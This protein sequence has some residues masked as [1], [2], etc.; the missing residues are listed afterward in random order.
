MLNAQF[1][2]GYTV[3][4]VGCGDELLPSSPAY[5]AGGEMVLGW[6]TC[7]DSLASQ[8]YP[9][10]GRI[11]AEFMHLPTWLDSFLADPSLGGKPWRH[12]KCED[13]R[14]RAGILRELIAE[15]QGLGEGADEYLIDWMKGDLESLECWLH[16]M[17]GE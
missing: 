15:E 7:F 2:T 9:W 12:L 3:G 13:A 8:V 6:N 14:K 1:F 10:C 11:K 5:W 16:I 4:Q 17:L